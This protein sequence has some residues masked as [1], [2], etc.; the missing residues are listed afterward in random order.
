MSAT[1]IA[2]I[3]ERLR[4][5]LAPVEFALEDESALHA[6]HPGASSGGGHYRVRIVAQCFAGRPILA[7]HRM[8]YDALAD[9]MKRDIHALAIDAMA[10]A[11]VRRSAS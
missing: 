8:V 4:T 6:G 1:V 5:T 2:Q 11:D 7:R 9:L 10:P 3:E